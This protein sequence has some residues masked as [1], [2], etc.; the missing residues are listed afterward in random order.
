[1][2]MPNN[3]L[4]AIGNTLYFLLTLQRYII[5]VTYQKIAQYLNTS[6]N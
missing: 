2:S 5:V 1:M 3:L 6:Y 4:K